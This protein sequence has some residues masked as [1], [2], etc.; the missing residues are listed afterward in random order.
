MM[1]YINTALRAF[2]AETNK[3]CL[4]QHLDG[5]KLADKLLRYVKK[6]DFG[7]AHPTADEYIRMKED[8]SSIGLMLGICDVGNTT[9]TKDIFATAE[10][11]FPNFKELLF[12]FARALFISDGAEEIPRSKK[13]RDGFALLEHSIVTVYLYYWSSVLAMLI[14]ITVLYRLNRPKGNDL[15]DALSIGGRILMAVLAT[16]L[17]A[18]YGSTVAWMDF[19]A[20]RAMLPTLC[21]I[22]AFVVGVDWLGRRIRVRKVRKFLRENPEARKESSATIEHHHDR[23]KEVLQERDRQAWELE[24]DKT[25]TSTWVASVRQDHYE[26]ATRRQGVFI[27]ARTSMYNFLM[28]RN[29]PGPG[30]F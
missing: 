23:D 1:R 15:S 2:A 22:L 11:R 3:L 21:G 14:T 6:Y 26:R 5:A 16:V 13:G 25:A 8:I 29:P 4:Q 20:S 27:P 28:H 10:E 7:V 18:L 17:I 9:G 19:I 30:Q 24:E 12:H